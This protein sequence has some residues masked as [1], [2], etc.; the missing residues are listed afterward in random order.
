MY[1]RITS[2]VKVNVPRLRRLL[3]TPVPRD[4]MYDVVIVGGGVAGLGLGAALKSSP[5]TSRLR[6]ALVEGMDLGSSKT[7]GPTKESYSNRVVSLTP[8][9]VK[10]LKEIGA[11]DH[12]KQ[13]RTQPFDDMQVW[14]GLTGARIEFK[15]GALSQQYP[16][17]ATIVETLNIQHALLNRIDELGGVDIID[18]T[19][20]VKIG[21]GEETGDLDFSTWPQLELSNGRKLTARLLI[22]ADGANSPVRSFTKIESRGW[23][24][25]RHGVVATLKI[26][27]GRP[28]V[29]WQ[30]FLPTGPIAMLPL[31]NGYATL[32]WTTTPALAAKLKAMSHADFAA[33]VNA[34]FR[35][36]DVDLR[37]LY[38]AGAKEGEVKEQCEWRESVVKADKRE[39]LPPR[40]VEIQ[41]GSRASF[42]L[43]MRHADSYCDE[44]IALVGD[45][46]HTTH[47]LAGQGLNQGLAD[48]QSLFKSLESAVTH[49]QD[50]GSIHALE[51]YAH[52]R[53]FEN[54]VTL[55]AIDKLHKLYSVSSGPL[56]TARSW[57]LEVVNELDG[58]KTLFMK[59]AAGE[60]LGK[61]V[62]EGLKGM[63][64]SIIGA[65]LRLR[66]KMSRPASGPTVGRRQFSTS[67]RVLSAGEPLYPGHIPTG[68]FEKIALTIGSAAVSLKNPYRGDMVAV[69]GETTA[70]P[71]FIKKLRD[72]M[73]QSESGRQILRERPRITSTTLKLE[74][75]RQLPS[76]S[77]GREYAAWLDAEGVSPDTRAA[78]K[79]IDDEELA[80]VMQR[81]RESHDFYHAVTGLPITVDGELALK[82]FEWAN[83]GLPVAALSALATFGPLKVKK[84]DRKRLVQTYIPWALKNGMNG[85]SLIDIYWEN[86]LETD[87]DDLRRRLNITKPPSLR[88]AYKRARQEM[89]Q[90]ARDE[91]AKLKA[92]GSNVSM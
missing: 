17:I 36:S 54:H 45:A 15:T 12:I 89:K 31:P 35:L 43:K 92:S 50:V 63:A 67:K 65:G 6:I 8:A 14:D 10:L 1:R 75:L 57:G 11:W 42:P 76:N 86:E 74:D 3:S 18:K 71:Y 2:T 38:E 44:R 4:D 83:M 19:K 23:D 72:I 64:G 73:L 41:E 51:P 84:S 27:T 20:V 24:Y 9:S 59:R 47:P 91:M 70:S 37:Y 55:G 16:S 77:V 7:W 30:R 66:A 90:G 82:W 21:H 46:A 56:V 79:Y 61:A 52:E 29:A 33:L 88:E 48:V 60:D 80:Y 78:V 53:Y 81:Y 40:V 13:E 22:G 26:E 32:V 62:G 34:G 25:D 87:V 28:V 85:K 68:V 39:F 5:V 58:L 49:G 69:L